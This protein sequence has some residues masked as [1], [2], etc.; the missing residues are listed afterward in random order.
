MYPPTPC[1]SLV[2]SVNAT[3]PC[4]IGRKAGAGSV[5]WS[6]VATMMLAVIGWPRRIFTCAVAPVT[7][8]IR[9]RTDA[10]AALAGSRVRV[11]ASRLMTSRGSM[12]LAATI[13]TTLPATAFEATRPSTNTPTKA[14]SASMKPRANSGARLLMRLG[15]RGRASAP[16]TGGPASSLRDAHDSHFPNLRLEYLGRAADAVEFKLR[17]AFGTDP[18]G[19]EPSIGGLVAEDVAQHRKAAVI[20]DD[21]GDLGHLAI[22]LRPPHMVQDQV[23]RTADLSANGIQREVDCCRQDHGLEP[24][25]RVLG[26]VGMDGGH[27]SVMAGIHRLQDLQRLRPTCLADE[28]PIGPQAKAVS[29]QLSNVQLAAAL[30]VRRPVLE[31][32]HVRVLELELGRVLD[33]HDGTIAWPSEACR[34]APRRRRA[35]R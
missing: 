8:A 14:T 12:S 3:S 4:G 9:A 5:I 33:R 29:K 22:A 7:S 21:L 30:D 16:I 25:Q 11:R 32:H 10:G 35:P 15:A 17:Q 6:G 31:A 34:P 23:D 2:G 20:A 26:R 28:D 13:T 24:S 19:V 1:C 18:G 27:A